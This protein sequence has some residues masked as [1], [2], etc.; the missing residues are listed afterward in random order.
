M[1]FQN[2]FQ[3]DKNG[4]YALLVCSIATWTLL[5]MDGEGDDEI[6]KRKNSLQKG[7]NVRVVLGFEF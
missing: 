1:V 4:F 6:D 3:V 5:T 2:M 7:S